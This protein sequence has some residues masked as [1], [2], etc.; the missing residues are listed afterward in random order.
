MR[1]QMEFLEISFCSLF[2]LMYGRLFLDMIGIVLKN[3]L[4]VVLNYG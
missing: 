1:L 2:C 4:F 3:C